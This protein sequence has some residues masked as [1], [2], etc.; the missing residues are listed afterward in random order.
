MN[1]KSST[2]RGTA[3]R[4][5]GVATALA[6]TL[7][8]S[9][10]GSSNDS[11]ADGSTP[12][13]RWSANTINP[14]QSVIFAAMG[15]DAFKKEGL[16]VEF[17]PAQSNAAAITTGSTDV[18]VG[19]LSDSLALLDKGKEGVVLG[20]T[21]VDSPVGLIGNNDVK[22]IEDLA[23]K[24]TECRIANL[25]N[26]NVYLYVKYFSEKYD[27]KCAL[28]I[29]ADYKTTVDATVSGTFDAS[30]QN[31]PVGATVVALG[32]ANWLVDPTD[33]AKAA[34]N[35]PDFHIV[36]GTLATSTAYAKDHEAELK[37]Y[38]AAL[39][40]TQE[41]MKTA[42]NEEVAE[43]VKASDVDFWKVQSI[44]EI[45]S[46]ITGGG[47]FEN[48]FDA[49]GGEVSPISKDLWDEQ[50]ELSKDLGIEID[51]SDP[52]YSYES[53]YDGSYFKN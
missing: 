43:A 50:L 45:V 10:C 53:A 46:A 35:K 5:A 26:G 15:R 49:V 1:L 37:K 21:A 23:A 6:V 51:S 2:K 52:K 16:N 34:A 40:K 29:V 41:W 42:S 9:A 7:L 47:A 12:T 38:F 32:K 44:D 4:A 11:G 19:R 25:P 33:P 8:A 39:D 22:T 17:V 13:L 48:V 14:N 24:G 27:L 28:S 30:V 31:A 36:A 18:I 3:R 20:K